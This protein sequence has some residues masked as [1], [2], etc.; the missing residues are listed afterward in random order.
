VRVGSLPPATLEELTT[1]FGCL[2]V[3]QFTY[4]A[5]GGIENPP[6]TCLQVETR[7]LLNVLRV[8]QSRGL[9]VIIYDTFNYD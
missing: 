6:Q 3:T 8:C 4:P 7:H 2:V 9:S 1:R 5:V